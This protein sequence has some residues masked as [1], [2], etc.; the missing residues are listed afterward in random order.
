LLGEIKP[1]NNLSDALESAYLFKD[2]LLNKDTVLELQNLGLTY[3]VIE[4]Q[5]ANGMSG[6]YAT[7]FDNDHSFGD[8]KDIA[9]R[10]TLEEKNKEIGRD[11]LNSSN[12]ENIRGDPFLAISQ[13]VMCHITLKYGF[14]VCDEAKEGKALVTKGNNEI[15]TVEKETSPV[16]DRAVNTNINVTKWSNFT[17]SGQRFSVQIPAHWTVTESGNRF[18]EELPLVATDT[19]G[20]SSKIQSQFSVNV[21]KRSQSFNTNQLAK[22]AVDQLVKTVTGNK[23]VEPISCDKYTI[24]A[25]KA[26]SFV[27]SGDDKEGKRYGIL[28][29][30]TVDKYKS[31]HI[32]SY[33][34]DALNFDNEQSTMDHIIDSYSLVKKAQ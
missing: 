11:T 34:A 28:A 20:S 17:D 19:N 3:M 15:K 5:F 33:R 7:A 14:Q 9:Y 18:T 2:V 13:S 6:I 29:V 31:N 24:D 1:Y 25:L 30:V 12:V 26:C 22:F 32:L 8:S 21:F 4:V 23:L 10:Q 16:L 27:Y